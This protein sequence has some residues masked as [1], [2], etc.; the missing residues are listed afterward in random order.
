MYTKT[1]ASFIATL[2]TA[3]VHA[4]P[5]GGV[6]F[7]DGAGSFADA[8]VSYSPGPDVGGNYI[9]PSN[10][11]GIPDWDVGTETGATSLGS[12]GELILQFTDNSLTTSGDSSDDLWIFEVGSV[13]EFFNVAIS[14]NN[15]TWIN[16]GDVLGQPTGIDIDAI[17]GVVVGEL[18]SFVR[19]TD[20]LPEQTGAPFGEADIDAVG[21][22]S[23]APPVNNIPIPNSVAL[24]GLGLLG[25]RIVRRT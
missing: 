11:L 13:T 7:P 15:S 18:Y 23:S 17:S 5:I 10:A 3:N 8:V 20:I 24:L 19:L 16:L 22:I 1:V 4:I 6:E 9:N 12:G 14:T 21:A 25:L 2:I